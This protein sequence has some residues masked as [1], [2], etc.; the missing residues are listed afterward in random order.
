MEGVT[1]RTEDFLFMLPYWDKLTP[2]E[3]DIV[4]QNAVIRKYNSGSHIHSCDR[5]C[6][7]MI[8]ILSGCVRTYILSEEGREITLFRFRENDSCVLSSSCVISQIT[9]E[10]NMDAE[11][12]CEILIVNASVFGK[13]KENNIYVRCYMY[14]ALSERFSSAMWTM[15]QILFEKLDKRLASF[16]IDEY[17]RTDSQEIPMTHEQIA[18]QIN[19]AREVVARMM[20]RFSSEGLVEMKRGKVILKNINGLEELT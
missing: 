2:Q 14:E 19:S 5:Q 7:G 20:K 8:Y 11:T 16:L 17:E 13:L 12:D 18:V 1:R 10:T 3:K 15:Q 6:L 9:F 4:L